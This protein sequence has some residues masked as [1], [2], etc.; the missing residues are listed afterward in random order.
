MKRWYDENA[1]E[2]KFMPGDRVFA[3]LPIPG[4]PFQ[5]RYHGPYTVDNN[6]DVNYIVNTPGSRKQKQL[7]LVNMLKQ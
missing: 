1:K 4:K 3:L 2:R 7:C 5:A 6:S